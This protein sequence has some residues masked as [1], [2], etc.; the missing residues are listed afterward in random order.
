MRKRGAVVH[1][2]LECYYRGSYRRDL[3]ILNRTTF[4]KLCHR[5]QLRGQYWHFALPC[6]SFSRM[7][8]NMNGGTRTNEKPEGSGDL[9]REI[10]GNFLLEKTICLIHILIRS[11][12]FWSLEN[13]R[14]SLVFYMPSVKEIIELPE[15]QTIDLDRSVHVWAHVQRL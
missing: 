3:D 15:T 12:N 7:S 10:L 4:E 2:P 11:G 14:N 9:D 8:V 1:T 6:K 13:P 5:A